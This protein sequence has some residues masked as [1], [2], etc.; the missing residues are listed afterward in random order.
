MKFEKL[1][2]GLCIVI[3]SITFILFVIIVLD[4]SETITMTSNTL[5]IVFVCLAVCL[6]ISGLGCCVLMAFHDDLK[7][8]SLKKNDRWKK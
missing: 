3:F 6:A 2:K 5:G 8:R 7:W 4:T 1:M